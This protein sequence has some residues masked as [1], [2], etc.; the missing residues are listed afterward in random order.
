VVKA[1]QVAKVGEPAVKASATKKSDKENPVAAKAEHNVKLKKKSSCAAVSPCQSRN[2]KCWRMQKRV[3]EGRRCDKKERVATRLF[4]GL[5]AVVHCS[6]H[7][8]T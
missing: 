3:P 7:R 8:S 5:E 4:G 6:T 2:T 1:T